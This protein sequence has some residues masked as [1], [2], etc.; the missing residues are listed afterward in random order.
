MAIPTDYCNKKR[1]AASCAVLVLIT[2]VTIAFQSHFSY[3][4]QLEQQI[5]SHKAKA[6]SSCGKQ[7]MKVLSA[8]EKCPREELR[9]EEPFCMETGYKQQVECADGRH[10]YNW[11]D[12]TPAVEERQFWLFELAALLITCASYT[13][14]YVRQRKNDQL[15]MEKINRQIGLSA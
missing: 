14:V 4:A 7:E 5:L 15:L 6:N 3:T 1:M 2:L 13:V 12:I 8:C 10:M 11:C 9:N